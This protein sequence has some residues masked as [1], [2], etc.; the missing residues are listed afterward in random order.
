M[1]NIVIVNKSKKSL[2]IECYEGSQYKFFNY[3]WCN[4]YLDLVKNFIILTGKTE[5]GSSI[6][7]TLPKS[8]TNYIEQN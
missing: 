5:S 1:L 3:Q 2:H 4:T 7:I 8:N 6:E